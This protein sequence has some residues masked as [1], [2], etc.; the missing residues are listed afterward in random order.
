MD[1]YQEAR[2]ARRRFTVVFA[3]HGAVTG[4]FVTRIPWI[5]EHLGLTPGELGL[6]LVAPAI[7][8]SLAMPMAGRVAHRY[9]S[10]AAVRG[11]MVLW[12]LVL[13]LPALAP[14]LAA[15]WAALLAYGA[16]SGMASVQLNAQGVE[17]ERRVGRSIMAGL[18]GMWSAGG[19]LASG[20]GVLAAHQDLDARPQLALTAVLLAGLALLACRELADVRPAPDEDAPPRFGLPPRAALAIGAVGFCGVFAEGASMD[21]GGVYLR[22]VTGASPSTAAFAF[23]AFAATMSAARLAGD[24][25]VRRL[26][27]V[28]TV[29]LG[30]S[31]AALGGAL[32]V[33]A[34]SPGLAVPG[35]GL[36]GIGVAVVVPLAFAA[37]GR[38]AEPSRAIAGVAT[39]TYTAGLLAPA[40]IGVVAQAAS[41]TVSFV[42]VT[43]LAA[44]LVLTAGALGLRPP[45]RPAARG[46]AQARPTSATTTASADATTARGS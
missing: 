4:S 34:S 46:Q 40:V 1:G 39:L 22:D 43:A 5:Q 6:A 29:R 31:V 23:T 14:N 3:V 10:R 37:A 41:L 44:A 33:A 20:L 19:L 16:T 8:A 24:L 15:F 38:T 25:V 11:L 27:P 32:V 28:R 17:V 13:A 21:W 36:I 9:G 7:G 30:G 42:L 26:G 45:A 18:H 12:C 2:R 35:F